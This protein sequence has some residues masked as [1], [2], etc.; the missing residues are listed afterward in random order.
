MDNGCIMFL[1][2]V[3]P[4]VHIAG[5]ACI[6]LDGTEVDFSLPYT[7]SRLENPLGLG[8]FHTD[9][10]CCASALHFRRAF[11]LFSAAPNNFPLNVLSLIEALDT[12]CT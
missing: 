10:I 1:I 3:E 7:C 2:R 11:K 9:A 5:C 8:K 12:P 4:E 6:Q